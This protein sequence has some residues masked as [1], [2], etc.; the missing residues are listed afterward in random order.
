MLQF[1]G[2]LLAMLGLFALA[3]VAA[4]FGLLAVLRTN[5]ITSAMLEPQVVAMLIYAGG[6]TAC[7]LLL[8]PSAYYS[9]RRMSG[10][11]IM[12]QPHLPRFFR[13]SILILF[14]PVVLLLGYWVSSRQQISWFIL[15]FLHVLAIGLPILF[16]LYLAGRGLPAGSPQR[17]WGV[18]GSGLTLGPALIMTLE[19]IAL[20]VFVIIGFVFLFSQPDLIE[21]VNSLAQA[22]QQGSMTEQDLLR[23]LLPWAAKP[24]LLLAV[25]LF[26]SV[27]VPLIEEAFKPI[28]VWLL[29]GAKLSPAAGFYA[30]ALCGA[31]F[32]FFESLAL[33]GSSSEWTLAVVSRI[34]AG[35]I[36]IFNSALMGWA[37]VLAWR[38]RRYLNLALTYLVVVAV[39]GA[40]NGLAILSAFEALL[41]EAGLE[42]ASNAA[43]Q[44]GLAAPYILVMIGLVMSGLMIWM[45]ARMRQTLPLSTPPPLADTPT[46]APDSEHPAAVL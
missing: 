46:P 14:L 43:T 42:L 30:G 24:G 29:A 1:V 28:G 20:I 17:L 23:A 15:P 3:G 7:A 38:K 35:V 40:W 31:G 8:V 2:T 33:G 5:V 13:P 37:L 19:T 16:I 10:R 45:N 9:L 39:H 6:L 32:A 4:A 21:Q 36:H 11:P 27:I 41:S 44:L 18:L 26:A 34:G 22:V 25:I 12:Q